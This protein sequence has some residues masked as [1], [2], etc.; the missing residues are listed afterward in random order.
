MGV[1]L[2]PYSKVPKNSKIIIYGAGK[3]G[4]TY[5]Q[6]IL[7]TNYCDVIC[8]IDKS[9]SLYQFLT[10]KVL[11]CKSALEEEFDYIIIANAKMEVAEKI[12]LLLAD[13][14]GVPKDKIIYENN[15]FESRQHVHGI[16]HKV[17]QACADKLAFLKT[18]KYP[19]AIH[20]EG[21]YGDYI[22]RKNNIEEVSDWDKNILIDLYVGK[23]KKAFA[24][25]LFSKIGK[26]NLIVE[27]DELYYAERE[28]YLA[29]FRF[30]AFLIV[31]F[32]NKI[33][34]NALPN[35]LSEMLDTV[36]K[37]YND[38]GLNDVGISL[39]VHYARCKKDNLN[40]FTAY[41]RYGAFNVLSSETEIPLLEHKEKDFLELNLGSYITI[42]YG[43]DRRQKNI[44]AKVW[45]IEHVRSL[46]KM[47]KS[48]CPNLIIVQLGLQ[49][50]PLLDGC[51]HI[52][53]MDIEVVKYVLLH[54]R[55]HID[56]EGGLVHLATQLGTKCAVLFGPTPKDYYGYDCNINIDAE[57][58]KN[59]YWYVPDCISCYRKLEHPECMYELLPE[60]VMKCISDELEIIA[61][62]L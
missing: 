12:S 14:W 58:C 46:T 25:V 48:K 20:L 36:T 47:I 57:R 31:D 16:E 30:T 43:W 28:K 15:I 11:D 6:Q 26:I 51:E 1:Y 50:S 9:F 42:N 4:Q 53:D 17:Y 40:C 35:R 3:V 24:E 56:C 52:I 23:G 34:F 45:P 62:K 27:E 22:C 60:Y 49:D 55:L 38:Y 8:M 2:F 32:C 7:L 37:E 44:P 29:S 10:V 33:V 59:C 61:D 18:G 21:G 13:E 39:A 5:L 54:S 41:N 19:V